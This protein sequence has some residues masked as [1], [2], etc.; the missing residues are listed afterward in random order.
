MIKGIYRISFFFFFI[1]LLSY[2]L[3]FYL[4]LLHIF[5]SYIFFSSLLFS[6]FYTGGYETEEM[7]V[8]AIYAYRYLRHH[9]VLVPHFPW[10]NMSSHFSNFLYLFLH[11]HVEWI[12]IFIFLSV[13]DDTSVLNLQFLYCIIFFPSFPIFIHVDI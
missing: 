4:F 7:Y 12:F 6:Y 1:F 13:I 11:L 10:I 9:K 2:F 8:S 3:F 5:S